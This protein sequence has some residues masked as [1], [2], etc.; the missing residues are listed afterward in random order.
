MEL[1]SNFQI[2]DNCEFIPMAKQLSADCISNEPRDG[3]IV[4]VR[5][6]E[7]KIFYDI[8]DIYYAKIYK[9]VDSSKVFRYT[10]ANLPHSEETTPE[11]LITQSK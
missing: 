1:P 2:G 11:P 7:A 4:A 5:F 8:F 10:F 6:T 3:K 9:N